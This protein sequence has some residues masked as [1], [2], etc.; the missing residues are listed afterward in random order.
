MSSNLVVVAIP[1]RD[2]P[3]W[4]VSSEKVPHMTLLFLGENTEDVPKLNRIVEFVEHATVFSGYGPSML[5]VDERGT[6]GE[7]AA[8]VLFFEKD[9][10]IRNLAE[11][12][13]KLLQHNDIR[14]AYDSVDQYPEWLP[15][16]TLGYP[17]TPA[18]EDE[19]PE[20]GLNWITFD[21]IAVWTEDFDGP[22]FK[23]KWPEDSM[24]AELAMAS[25]NEAR[26]AL[27]LDAVVEHY[28]VKGMKWGVRRDPKDTTVRV[29][30]RNKQVTAKKA[31]KLDKAFE[32]KAASLGV[33]IELHNSVHDQMNRHIGRINAI[34]K[35]REAADDGTLLDDSHPTTKKYHQEYMDAYIKEMQKVL[36]DSPRNLNPTGTKKLVVR[37]NA[38]ILGFTVS[39]V[40]VKHSV[41]DVFPLNVRFVKE[42]NGL[43]SD[44]VLEEDSM[45][46]TADLGAEFI[47]HFGV[48]GMRWGVRKERVAGDAKRGVKATAKKVGRKIGRGLD[49]LGEYFYETSIYSNATH[50]AIHNKVSEEI[51]Q[52]IYRLQTAPKYRGKNLKTDQDLRKEY[53]QDVE[54]V[55]EVA[56][57]R[58]VKDVVGENARGTKEARYVD[59]ARG[60]RIEIRD[61]RSGEI[62]REDTLRTVQEINADK[63]DEALAQAATDQDASPDITIPVKLDANGQIKAVGRVKS[64]VVHN[65]DL[66]DLGAEFLAHYGVKG[67]RW[68]VRRDEV[69][70]R[71]NEKRVATEAA[72]REKRPAQEVV[73]HPTIGRS[74]RAPGK[75][76]VKGGEDHPPAE[77][78]VKVAA[79]R[80]KLKKSGVEALSNN[81][82]REVANRL[83]LEQQVKQLESKKGS[84]KSKGRQFLE[85]QFKNKENRRQI[86]DWA[87]K[88]AIKKVATT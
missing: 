37:E 33:K 71:R 25:T 53:E 6:L 12:R 16:L 72:R 5:S 54:K 73:A 41:D 2:E 60:A 62:L 58:A 22:E 31:A 49:A 51:D 68:G 17:E 7:D 29:N 57:R 21:R 24:E 40:D 79:A 8:D 32:E 20:H 56:Y 82:L 4:K 69:L 55:T 48:K 30:G 38:D 59:D 11:L 1:A 13:N 27:G 26:K 28:G 35:Y 86:T 84:T 46:Q 3:V 66:S 44:F 23:L 81:E 42:S 83:Q 50:E 63:L 34:P 70:A 47:E 61:K 75:I 9:Y 43:I 80:Q 64:K 67:M 74:K 10:S 76:D 77:D 85:S 19:I 88:A 18:H 36:D 45:S 15:H 39:A 52:K 14:T 87:A 78:A 65:D